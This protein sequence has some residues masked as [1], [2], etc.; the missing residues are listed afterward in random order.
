[1]DVQSNV[2]STSKIR[3]WGLKNPC[4][5]RS[6]PKIQRRKTS[7]WYIIIDVLMT[8]NYR[9]PTNKTQVFN[10]I[11]MMENWLIIHMINSQTLLVVNLLFT[12]LKIPPVYSTSKKHEN[13]VWKFLSLFNMF[14]T[15]QNKPVQDLAYSYHVK[16]E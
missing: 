13:I 2:I 11:S 15:Y 6:T 16:L 14:Y 3:L 7:Y 8:S 1:M 5:K 9:N 12:I 10:E 4:V